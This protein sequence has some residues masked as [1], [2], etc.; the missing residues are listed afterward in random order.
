MRDWLGY[1]WF[2]VRL[3][4]R[5]WPEKVAWWLAWRLPRKVALLAFVRVYAVL[6]ECGPDYER[7]H[8]RWEA[9][10]GR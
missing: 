2:C 3:W 4:C 1:R 5:E 7:A 10:E 6:G 8:K 9:G